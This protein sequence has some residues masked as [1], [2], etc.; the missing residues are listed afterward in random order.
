MS[1]IVN[2]RVNKMSNRQMCNVKQL[3]IDCLP[4]R[5][6]VSSEFVYYNVNRECIPSVKHGK[7]IHGLDMYDK[8]KVLSAMASRRRK[9]CVNL[10]R[11][12]R[13]QI[14]SSTG[15]VLYT[16]KQQEV[17]NKCKQLV[18]KGITFSVKQV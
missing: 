9:R 1:N 16:L 2:H 8:S 6:T 14:V 5:Q 12:P 4:L 15:Q 7:H 18:N 10:A 3:S 13:Y 17:S 11:K